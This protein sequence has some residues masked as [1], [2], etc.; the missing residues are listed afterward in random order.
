MIRIFTR[1]IKA[2]S[3]L[4]V[5]KLRLDPVDSLKVVFF[6]ANASLI[7][8]KSLVELEKALTSKINLGV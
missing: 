6:R 7:V 3:S 4:G 5:Q 2:L 8:L 1:D